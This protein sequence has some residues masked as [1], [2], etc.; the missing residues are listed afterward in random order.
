MGSCFAFVCLFIHTEPKDETKL[1]GEYDL[2]MYHFNL[3][4][5]EFDRG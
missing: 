3:S 1:K 2:T 4:K 5:L